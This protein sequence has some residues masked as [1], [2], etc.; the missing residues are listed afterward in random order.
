MAVSNEQA[1]ADGDSDVFVPLVLFIKETS[2]LEKV[3][4]REFEEKLGKHLNLEIPFA[5]IGKYDG[6][7]VFDKSKVSK[8]M[9]TSLLEKGFEYEGQKVEF[10]IGSDKDLGDFMRNHGRH[11]GK[12]IQKSRRPSRRV[13]QGDGQAAEGAEEEVQ[14]QG[15]VPRSKLPDA[16]IV[17]GG[18]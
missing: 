12:I 16:R 1:A 9:L 3:I 13:R 4:G 11:V 8:E 15:R 7:V 5:R 17:E 18:L 10:S 14:G 2:H 6:N